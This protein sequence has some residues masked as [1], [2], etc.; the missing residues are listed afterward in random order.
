KNSAARFRSAGAFAATTA[1]SRAP[2]ACAAPSNFLAFRA[3]HCSTMC[4]AV[5]SIIALS[6]PAASLTITD[7]VML[8]LPQSLNQLDPMEAW[9]PWQPSSEQPWNQKWAA[10]LY[11]RAAFCPSWEEL[12]QA[13]KQGFEPTLQRLLAGGEGLE[14]FDELVDESA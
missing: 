4:C 2:F 8:K 7:P 13:V 5:H 10:H 1:R 9:K 11:R 3:L 14:D 6:Q 12:Q